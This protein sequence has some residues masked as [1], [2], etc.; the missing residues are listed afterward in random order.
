LRQNF[1]RPKSEPRCQAWRRSAFG[2]ARWLPKPNRGTE[3]EN[4]AG[5]N[6]LAQIRPIIPRPLVGTDAR[7]YVEIDHPNDVAFGVAFTNVDDGEEEGLRMQFNARTFRD[8]Q[9]GSVAG[10]RLSPACLRARWCD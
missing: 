6:A 4:V 1:G 3:D 10:E 9:S 5:N 8:L 2:A 7:L